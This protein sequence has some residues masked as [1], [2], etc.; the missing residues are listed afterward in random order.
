MSLPLVAGPLS[1]Q[2]VPDND[3]WTLVEK[4]VK[5]IP[6]T[7]NSCKVQTYRVK[8]RNMVSGKKQSEGTNVM[9]H[10]KFNYDTTKFWL[11]IFVQYLNDTIGNSVFLSSMDSTNVQDAVIPQGI[12]DFVA[13]FS[14][15]DFKGSSIE[16]F[17]KH[18]TSP[19]EYYVIKEN[20]EIKDGMTIEFDP[21]TCTNVV[22]FNP[23]L[24]NGE[25][26]VSPVARIDS[27]LQYVETGAPHN[28]EYSAGTNKVLRNDNS[29]G[30]TLWF[31]N[32]RIEG[33][34]CDIPNCNIA[35]NNVSD[36]YHFMQERLM[37]DTNGKYYFVPM[38]M[39]G[40]KND[41]V[42]NDKN[43][44]LTYSDTFMHSPLYTD[45]SSTNNKGKIC[46]DAYNKSRTEIMSFG[47]DFVGDFTIK[48]CPS[49][50][51][52]KYFNFVMNFSQIDYYQLDPETYDE[53]VGEIFG[54][55]V[56]EHNG[57]LS[58]V[59]FGHH[60]CNVD[61]FDCFGADNK[62]GSPFPGHPRFSYPLS[63]KKD[64][65]GNNSPICS[66]LT[67]LGY[68][69]DD[70]GNYEFTIVNPQYVGR[71]N[72]T[73][74]VDNLTLTGEIMHNDTV[75]CT[76]V[77]NAKEWAKQWYKSQ[78]AKGKMKYKFINS[79]INVDGIPGKNITEVTYDENCSDIFAPTLQMLQFSSTNNE[80]KDRFE[81]GQE[82]VLE[83]SCGDV[84]RDGIEVS[85]PASVKVEYAPYGS[86]DFYNLPVEEVPE[87]YYMPGLGYYY[88]GSLGTVKAVSTNGWF[89]LRVTLSDSVGNMQRQVISPAFKVSSLTGIRD[90]ALQN[91]VSIYA[92]KSQIYINGIDNPSVEIYD[93]SGQQ[94]ISTK[95]NRVEAN[96]AP[97]IYIVKAHRGE[98]IQ[99]AKVR[100]Q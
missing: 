6:G 92:V 5:Q 73:R 31:G 35:V 95:G 45:S 1:P 96:F 27:S 57:E 90:V 21:S 44:Y 78:H 3:A 88:R 42:T 41:T 26:P 30:N 43:D 60:N 50:E 34:K 28:V 70:D 82:G 63:Q 97:G 83:L 53:K 25:H 65:F 54:S 13:I 8:P 84:S 98:I 59:N 17:I 81:S 68:V 22:C 46:F 38:M 39:T 67:K 23:V 58:Y 20:V 7:K 11:P 37:V 100:I 72:E 52:N 29:V 14:K 18:E 76:D 16:D 64:A 9:V 12:Y 71:Y 87:Y 99:V 61:Y 33:Q 94:M 86:S 85:A 51:A 36:R 56:L 49:D 74:T 75:V 79:N 89:D 55:S 15:A 32:Y 93:L 69:F 66:A 19:D 77:K 10:L 4:N 40:V 24:P 80:I 47:G 62:F 91:G 2:P 48:Y